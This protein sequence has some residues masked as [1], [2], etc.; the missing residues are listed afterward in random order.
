MKTIME[1]SKES[2]QIRTSEP[3]RSSVLKML[4]AEAKKMAKEDLREVVES[5]LLNAARRQVKETENAVGLIRQGGG[6]TSQYEAELVILKAF[7]PPV[8]DETAISAAV[9]RVI[10]SLPVADRTKKSMGAIMAQL[11]EIEGMDM[12]VASKIIGQKLS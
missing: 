11:K 1:L 2:M 4:I 9:D 3:I 7:L 12:K 8:L 5:D 6:D 10:A